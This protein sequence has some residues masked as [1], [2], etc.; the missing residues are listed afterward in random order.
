MGRGV[1]KGRFE[2]GK[3]GLDGGCVFILPDCFFR[4]VFLRGNFDLDNL[5]LGLAW[6]V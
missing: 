1:G 4:L 5:P 6:T 3:R 2:V